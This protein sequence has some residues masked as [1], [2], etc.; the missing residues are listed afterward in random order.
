MKTLDEY[1]YNVRCDLCGDYYPRSLNDDEE[2][3]CS[4]CRE[5][6]KRMDEARENQDEIMSRMN[7]GSTSKNT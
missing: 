6:Q 1:T 7:E 2:L 3:I 5:E 4:L